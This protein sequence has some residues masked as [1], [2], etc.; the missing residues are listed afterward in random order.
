MAV[1]AVSE[2]TADPFAA[3]PP[4]RGPLH[5]AAVARLDSVLASEWE[6]P[7]DDWLAAAEGPWGD[8]AWPAVLLERLLLHERP[9]EAEALRIRLRQQGHGDLPRPQPPVLRSVHHL[10]CSGGTLISK[11]IASLPGV[12]LISEVNPTNRNSAGFH[13]TDPLLLLEQS[14]RPLLEGEIR[15]AIQA[16]IAQA[17]RI[18]AAA[19]VDLVLRDHSHSDV[20]RGQAPSEHP[21]LTSWLGG[22]YL[23]RPLVTLRHPLDCWLGLVHAGWQQQ[24]QPAT[25]REYIAR[26]HAFLQATEGWPRLHYEDFCADPAAGLKAMCE[27]LLLP[28]D[29][30]ALE[31]FGACHLSGDSGRGDNTLIRPRPRRPIDPSVQQELADPIIRSELQ[32]LCNRMGY[33]DIDSSVIAMA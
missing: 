32:A 28:F 30:I 27:A 14:W 16:D 23:L 8:S 24:F 31:R 6:L 13:P 3:R 17:V 10:A 7:M 12:A 9:W 2:F 26:C 11:V 33:D 18:C 21:W 19:D 29:R 20:C 5:R 22:D 15:E 25:L 1:M 4:W